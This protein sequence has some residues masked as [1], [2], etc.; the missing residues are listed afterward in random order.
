MTTDLQRTRGE[1]GIGPEFVRHLF[2][3]SRERRD[4][5]FCSHH[6]RKWLNSSRTKN[7]TAQCIT[8]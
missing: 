1:Y 8:R 2:A 5:T 6:A 4:G 3:S 7:S